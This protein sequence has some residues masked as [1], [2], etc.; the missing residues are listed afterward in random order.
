M[1]LAASFISEGHLKRNQNSF[2]DDGPAAVVYVVAAAAF[3][4]VVDGGGEI[5]SGQGSQVHGPPTTGDECSIL[6]AVT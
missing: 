1:E 4:F 3:A 2:S 6:V 5:V